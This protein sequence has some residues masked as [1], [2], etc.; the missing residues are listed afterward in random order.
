MC[1][2]FHQKAG[3]KI[4]KIEVKKIVELNNY[5]CMAVSQ[6]LVYYGFLSKLKQIIHNFN[7]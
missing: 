6:Q 2:F 5:S 7:T 4:N 1:I 3:P